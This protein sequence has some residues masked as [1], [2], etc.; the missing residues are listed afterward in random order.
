MRSVSLPLLVLVLGATG[1]ADDTVGPGQPPGPAPK[2]TSVVVSASATVLPVGFETTLNLEV[3]RRDGDRV[4]SPSV[5]WSVDRPDLA[6]VGGDGVVRALRGQG[7]VTVTATVEG[8]SGSLGLDVVVLSGRLAVEEWDQAQNKG[9]EV[10]PMDG[11]SR[12]LLTTDGPSGY[13]LAQPAWSPDGTRLAFT[14]PDAQLQTAICVSAAD[15]TGRVRIASSREGYYFG[16]AWSPDG[17]A[18]LFSDNGQLFRIASDGSGRPDRV[19]L[20]IPQGAQ[21]LGG[22]RPAPDGVRLAYLSYADIYDDFYSV[23][24]ARV[25]QN[26]ATCLYA[27]YA[28]AWSPDGATLAAILPNDGLVVLSGAAKVRTLVTAESLGGAMPGD[29]AWSPDG[30]WIA[31]TAYTFSQGVLDRDIYLVRATD[32][33]NLV[34]LATDGH[35]HNSP[36]W[37]R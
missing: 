18:I 19:L 7:R 26:A 30:Q 12:T 29:F 33:K 22:G 20:P 28:P 31:M 15:G 34:R 16:P 14:C 4:G 17:A 11:S 24:I 10:I 8:V 35:G 1:C 27:G 13:S 25:G 23:C 5:A 9:I 6:Q 36:S 32:G 3:R 2:V 21:Y 37:G